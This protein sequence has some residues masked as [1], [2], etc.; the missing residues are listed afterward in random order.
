MGCLNDVFN[1]GEVFLMV[2][3]QEMFPQVVIILWDVIFTHTD[4]QI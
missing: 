2:E 1:T 4:F 3:E